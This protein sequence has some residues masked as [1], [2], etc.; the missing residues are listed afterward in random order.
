MAKES[1]IIRRVLSNITYKRPIK[2]RKFY[3]PEVSEDSSNLGEN[4]GSKEQDT[5]EVPCNIEKN[6]EYIKKQFN[7]PL[8][9]DIVIKQFNVLGKYRAFIVYIDGMADRTTIND[10]ILRP[11]MKS[12]GIYQKEDYELDYILENVIESNQTKK[13]NISADVINEILSGDTG[14][15]IDGWDFYIFSETKGYEKRNVEGPKVEGLVRGPQEGFNENLRTNITLLRKIIKN[16]NFISETLTIGRQTRTICSICYINGIVNPAIVKEV[17][18]RINSIDIDALQSSGELEQLIEDSP[19]SI[20]PTI[21]STE[22]PDKASKALLEGKAAII[23]DGT[24][25]ALVVP[26]TAADLFHS[27]ED[28]YLRWQY[29]TLL[30]IVRIYAVI[31]ATLLPG[32]YIAATNFHQEMIPTEI[33]IAISKAR[34][35]VPFPTI[36]EI[37]LMESSFELIREAGIR[38]PGALGNTIGIVGAIILG[39]AAVQADIISPVIIIIISITGLGSFAIPDF[40]FSLGLRLVRILFIA[41][42]YFLGF[43]GITIMVIALASLTVDMKSFGVPFMSIY[44]PKVYKNNDKIF[45]YPIWQQEFRP[46][47]LNSLNRRKQ[48]KKLRKWEYEQDKNSKD[49]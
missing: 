36:I 34:E 28:S 32:L 46:D 29:G 22:R 8:N 44:V 18:R 11:L 19:V 27:P 26:I 17:K 21:L 33:L 43:Y 42:G 3:I 13:V 30:R 47:Q 35:N 6:I 15:Y 1:K 41:A 5:S 40:S 10:F 4:G 2:K 39:Q 31:V 12:K 48:V 45:R 23:V 9:T 16:N 7:Y 37:L 14:L 24:P 38:V 25:F 49:E 20:V